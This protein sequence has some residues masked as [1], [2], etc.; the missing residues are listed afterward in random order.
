MERYKEYKDSQNVFLREIPVGWNSV[1]MKYLFIERSEK[2]HPN[3][4]MLSATQ[5]EGVILQSKYKNRVVVVNKG[6]EGLKLVKVGD[7]VIHLR[8]FQGGIEYTYDQGI[9]SSAY[10]ILKP[11][12]HKNADYFKY[13]FKSTRFIDMLKTCVTGIREGQNINYS[14]LKQ[15]FIPIP[16]LPEQ[17]AIVSYL[18]VK[19]AKCD[20]LI[21]G[22]EKQI[23]LL[24]ELKQRIIADAVTR[25]INKNVK[26]KKTNVSWVGEVPEHWELSTLRCFLTLYSVKNH[27]GKQLLSVTREQGVIIRNTESKEENHNFIPSDLSGYKYVQAGDFCINKMKAWQ[28]SYGVSKYEGIVSPAYYT[29][30]L[31]GVNKDFF[32]IAVRSKTYISFF[33]QYSKGIRVEQWDLSAIALK[34]IPFLLPPLS[35][36]HAIVSYITE[37]TSKIDLLTSKLQKE[38]EHLKEYKQRL[39]SDVVTGQ[40]KVCTE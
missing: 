32:S 15:Y 18:D 33:A 5:N 38:I 14:K 9:I 20:K 8:S 23:T 26:Y 25:G 30:K 2:N 40:I 16:P 34:E 1:K 11:R 6:F 28:G 37:K 12:S 24:Q 29:C 39:I 7:F 19:C 17:R 13:L 35:E 3:E 22:N 21:A 31:K 27:P 4:P 10:T 36:Q